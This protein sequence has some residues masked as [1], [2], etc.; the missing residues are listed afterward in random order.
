MMEIIKPNHN[1]DFTAKFGVVCTLSAIVSVIAIILMFTKGFNFGVD[2]RG[3]AEIQV[4]FGANVNVAEVRKVLGDG[5][6]SGAMVQSIGEASNNEYLIKV[7][8]TE[9]N[10]NE[11]SQK[12]T[13]LLKAKFSSD[14]VEVRKT[15]IVGPKAGKQLR[16][17]SAKAM[18]YALILIMVY[19]AMRF[20]FKYAPGAI[21]ALVHDVLVVLGAWSLFN[22][23]F[24]L[25]TV[26]AILA[27]IGYSVNDTVVIYDRVRE[28][29]SIHTTLTLTEQINRS[30]NETLSRTVITVGATLLV[31]IAMLIWGGETTT[32][33][34]MAFTIGAIA[35]CYSSIFIAAP[36]TLFFDKMNK[37]NKGLKVQSQA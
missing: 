12:V 4:K 19:I 14:N 6:I 26:A 36:V 23:E 22:L 5:G 31:C 20:D 34:F 33:F 16:N 1:I 27:I 7:M 10:L 37:K 11:V 35:G 21:I 30:L 9:S 8:A 15:D 18:V 3:G 13:D 25:Q 24:S 2:F 29:E 17:S 28:N 32:P